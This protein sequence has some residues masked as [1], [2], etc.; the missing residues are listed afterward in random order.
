LNWCHPPA[1][2]PRNIQESPPPSRRTLSKPSWSLRPSVEGD[3]SQLS[4]RGYNST[5]EPPFRLLI[6]KSNST[7]RA[8]CNRGEDRY[9]GRKCAGY[10]ARRPQFPSPKPADGH[11]WVLPALQ[12]SKLTVAG[13]FRSPK[14]RELAPWACTLSRIVGNLQHS[15]ATLQTL[16][17]GG[18]ILL[19]RT[20]NQMRGV[21]GVVGD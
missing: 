21:E 15:F 7:F 1:P 19:Y 13:N 8:I 3:T 14:P 17:C 16:G 11:P 12:N 6:C 18:L 20:Y 4:R 10:S 9:F 5:A 2:L